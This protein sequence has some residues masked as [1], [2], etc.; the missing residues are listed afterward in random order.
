MIHLWISASLADNHGIQM[1]KTLT[2]RTQ[3]V[4]N[5]PQSRLIRSGGVSVIHGDT[6]A[7]R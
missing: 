5:P 2:L 1:A 4:T 7:R 3:A 6:D